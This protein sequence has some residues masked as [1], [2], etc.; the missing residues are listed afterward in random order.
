M[1]LSLNIFFNNYFTCVINII[2]DI[3]ISSLYYC[4]TCYNY[5]NIVIRFIFIIFINVSIIYKFIYKF[6]YKYIYKIIYNNIYNNIYKIIY[7]SIYKY[8]K[9]IKFIQVNLLYL[10]NQ[11]TQIT[12]ANQVT[13]ITL[14]SLIIS[15]IISLITSLIT[16]ITSLPLKDNN[17]TDI[18]I[19]YNSTYLF[20]ITDI[21]ANLTVLYALNPII[22]II[23]ALLYAIASSITSSN[24]I[25]CSIASSYLYSSVSFPSYFN[26]L[27]F[28]LTIL[29]L[30]QY[31]SGTLLLTSHYIWV[32]HAIHSQLLCILLALLYLHIYRS[33]AYAIYYCST[34]LNLCLLHAL[35][36][37]ICSTSIS[38]YLLSVSFVA[39]DALVIVVTATYCL[40]YCSGY[41]LILAYVAHIYLS[42]VTAAVIAYHI[43]CVHLSIHHFKYSSLSYA[44][45]YV[46]VT[47]VIIFDLY[48]L[49]LLFIFIFSSSI[50]IIVD[51]S[52]N[53][54]HALP[55]LW[56]LAVFNIVAFIPSWYFVIVTA[57]WSAVYSIWWLILC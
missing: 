41:L 55:Y 12:L 57:L 8:I 22:Y 25:S 1:Y 30:L 54:L 21:T 15:K 17:T 34:Y 56:I 16:L 35:C 18:N 3:I 29:C 33:S 27:S 28:K 23:N 7:K 40:N 48:Y 49:L 14:I 11:V 42:I 36:C 44:W 52:I 38:G 39:L 10:V 5:Y 2:T 43:V 32:V 47:D 51:S 6:I 50:F 19:I 46:N 24:T 31:V 13:Q 37:L 26:L 9:F 20:S 4:Y 53:S 45:N